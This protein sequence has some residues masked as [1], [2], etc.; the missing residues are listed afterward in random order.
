MW[1]QLTFKE[2]Q[3]FNIKHLKIWLQNS[4]G[5]QSKESASKINISADF[6][7]CISKLSFVQRLSIKGKEQAFLCGQP[8]KIYLW[9]A[10]NSTLKTVETYGEHAGLQVQVVRRVLLRQQILLSARP[11]ASE[12]QVFLQEEG[13]KTC[14]PS[15][16][17]GGRIYSPLLVLAS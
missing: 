6:S 4:S 1:K 8:K 7:S 2:G 12:I 17:D 14:L 10:L 13:K 9:E 16:L 11:A 3:S 5:K 15:D